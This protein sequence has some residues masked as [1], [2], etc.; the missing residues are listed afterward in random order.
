MN[1]HIYLAWLH[2]AW[3]THPKLIEIFQTSQNYK[4]VYESMTYAS[5]LWFGFTQAQA[6]AILE[7]KQNLSL[8]QIQNKL[9]LRKARIVTLHDSEYPKQLLNI[10]HV[11]YILYVRGNIS[12]SPSISVVGARSMTSY[13]KKIIEHIVSGVSNYFTIVSWWA[14]GCDTWAHKV[15]LDN[16]K[17]TLSIIG[18]GIDKDYPVSNKQIYDYI[19]E[20]W[21][22]VISI[23][24]VGQEWLPYNFPIRNEL[25]AGISVGTIIVEAREKSGTLITANLALDM[26][27]DLFSV[28]WD[29][30]HHYSVGC[31]M[32][33]QSGA[34]KPVLSAKC[35]L[36]EYNIWQSQ[37]TAK[38]IVEKVFH[39]PQEENIYSIL[40]SES[41]NID[42]LSQKINTPVSEVSY[43]T[44][45]LEIGGHIKKTLGGKYEII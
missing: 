42:T 18:T 23:F 20:H 8:Q 34:A 17:S 35:I 10:P 27:K 15:A 31:N 37:K 12:S 26:W 28:P 16:K 32:L 25:V 40:L 44:S 1:T 45:L 6:D 4:E 19:A 22:A 30:F 3:F 2:A 13:G 41:V 38:K 29:I 14:A 24:P 33:I 5:L 9:L 39:H 7:K 36:E 43:Y 21:G 11:P